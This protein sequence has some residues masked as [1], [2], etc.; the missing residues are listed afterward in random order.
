MR[1]L[2]ERDKTKLMYP[3][4]LPIEEKNKLFYPNFDINPQSKIKDSGST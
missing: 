2:K 3:C 1:E 4:P